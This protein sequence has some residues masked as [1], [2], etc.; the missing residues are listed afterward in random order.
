MQTTQARLDFEAQEYLL[1]LAAKWSEQYPALSERIARA[2][3]F[4]LEG[5]VSSCDSG[6][7]VSSRKNTYTVKIVDGR[8]ICHCLDAEYCPQLRCKHILAC[9]LFYRVARRLIEKHDQLCVFAAQTERKE[10]PAPKPPTI[11]KD[12]RKLE[13]HLKRLAQLIPPNA[14]VH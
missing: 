11:K 8:A 7:Q 6:Y 2:R 1:D 14:T 12:Q 5:A 3:L 4:V 10:T 9:G 13:L